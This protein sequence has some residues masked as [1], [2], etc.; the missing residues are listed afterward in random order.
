MAGEL[1]ENKYFI[2]S[3]FYIKDLEHLIETMVEGLVGISEFD[4][5]NW[6]QLW[7]NE[8]IFQ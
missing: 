1:G 3:S 8:G 2:H 5:E 7:R 6:Q 4:Y